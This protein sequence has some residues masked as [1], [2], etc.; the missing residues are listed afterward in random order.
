MLAIYLIPNVFPQQNEHFLTSLHITEKQIINIRQ[1]YGL[2]IG[3]VLTFTKID[4]F[5]GD[6]HNIHQTVIG[7]DQKQQFR[8][9]EVLQEELVS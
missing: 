2:N 5:T 9:S 4:Q 3:E 6:I 8:I 7:L 1:K